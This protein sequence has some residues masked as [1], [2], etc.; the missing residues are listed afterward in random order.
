MD[1]G[2]QRRPQLALALHLDFLQI[3]LHNQMLDIRSAYHDLWPEGRDPVR[4]HDP[5]ISNNITHTPTGPWVASL[6]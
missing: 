5:R 2:H 6:R 1:Q 3:T 4:L